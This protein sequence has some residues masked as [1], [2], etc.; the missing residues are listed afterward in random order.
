MPGAATRLFRVAATTI[1]DNRIPIRIVDPAARAQPE[2]MHRRGVP[3]SEARTSFTTL[4]ANAWRTTSAATL[5][6]HAAQLIAAAH[7]SVTVE[8][9]AARMQCSTRHLHRSMVAEIGIAPKA[10][11]RIARFRRAARLIRGGQPLAVVA[12]E[13]G[14]GDQAHMTRE[15]AALGAPSPKRLLALNVR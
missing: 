7:G 12:L 3:L 9:L 1:R 6:R 14:Y 8:E 15:F 11:A 5:A 4:L 13:A 2:P 10:A